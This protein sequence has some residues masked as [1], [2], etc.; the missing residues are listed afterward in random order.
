M[1]TQIYRA[2]SGIHLGFGVLCSPAVVGIAAYFGKSTFR[3]TWVW[4][5]AE[6]NSV[7][8]EDGQKTFR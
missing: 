3:E 6:W 8:V 5:W 1:K 7:R 2:L 4:F